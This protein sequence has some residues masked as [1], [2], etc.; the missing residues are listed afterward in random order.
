MRF[1]AFTLAALAAGASAQMMN[2]TALLG[3]TPELSNLTSYVSLFPNLLT[4]L[5]SATDITILS[6]SSAAFVKFLNTSM[7][8]PSQ[9]DLIRAVLQYHVLNGTFP[10]SAIKST[11]AFIPTL[12]DNPMFENVTGGQVVE[13]VMD[14]KSVVFSSGLLVNST[15][16]K[17]VSIS[18]TLHIQILILLGRQHHRRRRPRH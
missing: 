2:L 1:Q 16:T 6:P 12:L 8:D 18:S 14:D 9:T 5:G 10:A 4:T 11:P 7:I 13:A 17:A 3:A 15:V